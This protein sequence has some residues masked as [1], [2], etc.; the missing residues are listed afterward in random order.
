MA[1]PEYVARKWCCPAEMVAR[2]R[3]AVFAI[4]G[5]LP[6]TDVELP[7]TSMKVTLPL[8][9]EAE[10]RVTTREPLPYA[11][12]VGASSER[13]PGV[14]APRPATVW[15]RVSDPELGRSCR[16]RWLLESA[17]VTRPAGDV[18]R[19]PGE[20]RTA[21]AAEVPSPAKPC[22]EPPVSMVRLPVWWSRRSRRWRPASAIYRLPAASAVRPRGSSREGAER[23]WG[24]PEEA[25]PR[26]VVMIPVPAAMRR[27]RL[28]CTSAT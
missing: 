28:L 27:T 19:A 22:A 3:V 11:V 5:M 1:S 10:L 26:S 12:T 25:G 14:E 4:R 9:G 7:L 13:M 21:A 6:A 24:E 2:L 15:M 18:A 16:T 17:I 20:S 23:G 8:A